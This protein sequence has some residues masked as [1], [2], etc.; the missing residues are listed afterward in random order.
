M[1]SFFLG[2]ELE[3]ELLGHMVTVCLNL[4][5]IAKVFS[6]QAVS[7]TSFSLTLSIV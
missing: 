3:V 6:K 7:I 5:I 1:V 4:W 2:V